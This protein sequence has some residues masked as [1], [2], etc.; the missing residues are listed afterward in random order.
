MK[1]DQIIHVFICEALAVLFMSLTGGMEAVWAQMHQGFHVPLK[2]AWPRVLGRC[3]PGCGRAALPAPF[4]AAG[5]LPAEWA[6]GPL[7]A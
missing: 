3:W 2:A 5:R 7:H 1:G 4:M 6:A